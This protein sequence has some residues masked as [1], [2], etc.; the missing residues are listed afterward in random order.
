[1]EGVALQWFISYLE[2]RLQQVKIG[3]SWSLAKF[4]MF[5]VPQGSVLGPL[6]FLIYMLPLHHLILAHGLNLHGFADDNQLY[7]T[8]SDPADAG[9][10]SAHCAQIEACVVDINKW[11]TASKLKLNNDKTEILVLGTDQRVN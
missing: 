2:E 1:M 9:T 10:V 11:M 8:I 5:S 4:L 7:L 6:L 3:D